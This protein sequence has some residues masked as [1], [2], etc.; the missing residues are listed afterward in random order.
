MSKRF[1]THAALRDVD[2]EVPA[3][4]FAALLGPSGCGKTTMLMII[5]GFEAPDGG[6]VLLGGEDITDRPA[7]RRGMGIVF[8]NYALFP[9][10]SAAENI[11]YPLRARRMARREIAGR[12]RRV[13]EMLEIGDLL[14]RAP[15]QLSGGQRQ[16]VAIARAIVFE[17]QLLLMDEPLSALDRNLR[18]RMK[19]E[20]RRLHARIGVTTVMVTHDQ[21]EAMEM[22]DTVAVM[23]HGRVAEV[24]SPRRLYE[25]PESVAVA[26]FFGRSNLLRVEPTPAGPAL[27]GRPL[28]PGLAAGR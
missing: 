8:Q 15:R 3:G 21:D 13:A 22:A 1:G 27:A 25:R 28:P 5:A 20:I 6:R 4:A 9:H 26:R 10:M 18:E 7:E 16:R 17:P 11:A 2:L 23:E 19:D 12:V 14:A 24:G